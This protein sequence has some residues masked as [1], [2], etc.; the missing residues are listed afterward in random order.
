MAMTGAERAAKARAKRKAGDPAVHY[1]QPKK[2]MKT[3]L[4]RWRDAVRELD[5]LLRDY[6]SWRGSMPAPLEGSALAE[7]LDALLALRE[8]VDE[9]HAAELPRGFG[10]D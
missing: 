6:E 5:A 2:R 10:R 7:K 8:L 4:V 3:R 9:L 1:V